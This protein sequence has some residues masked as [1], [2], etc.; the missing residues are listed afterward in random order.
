M[1]SGSRFVPL[2][3]RHFFLADIVSLKAM[4]RAVLRLRQP[5]VLRVRWRALMSTFVNI[6]DRDGA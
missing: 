2:S 5:F 4:D 1:T 3:F 6:A